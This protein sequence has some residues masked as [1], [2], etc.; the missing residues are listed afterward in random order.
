MNFQSNLLV[1]NSLF[2]THARAHTHTDECSPSDMRRFDRCF[3]PQNRIQSQFCL[4]WTSISDLNRFRRRFMTDLLFDHPFM[5]FLYLLSAQRIPDRALLLSHWFSPLSGQR[6]SL[7]TMN[8]RGAQDSYEKNNNF[9][10]VS[11]KE[12]DNKKKSS[13][14]LLMPSVKNIHKA[15][16]SVIHIQRAFQ[17]YSFL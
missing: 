7:S 2:I 14:I 8:E 9:K 10:K 3:F 16:F 5:S 13:V 1:I 15:S 12:K 17:P 11:L 6:A 4:I